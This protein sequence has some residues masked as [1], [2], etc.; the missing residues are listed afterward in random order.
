MA[1]RSVPRPAKEVSTPVTVLAD[2]RSEMNARDYAARF[3]ARTELRGLQDRLVSALEGI[4]AT[5][6][7]LDTLAKLAGQRKGEPAD[8]LNERIKEIRKQ[9]D[10]VELGFR[11]PPETRGIVFDDDKAESRLAMA[12]GYV[13]G[14]RGSPSATA[15]AYVGLARNT[16]NSALVALET[17]NQGPLAE[18]RNAVSEAGIGLLQPAAP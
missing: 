17:F 9:L 18:L 10:E 12:E 8:Q 4:A 11:V 14:S 7:D 5:R 6:T 1:V 3:A 16:L 13:A 2:P 15:V